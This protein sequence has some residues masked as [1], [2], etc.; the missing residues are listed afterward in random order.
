MSSVDQCVVCPRGTFCSVGA[1]VATP[2]APGTFNPNASAQTCTSCVSGTFQEARGRTAC[3]ACS[4][5]HYCG[6]GAAAALP[7]PGG[8]FSNRTSLR[9]MEQCVPAPSG[10]F[11]GIGQ[12]AA[13]ACPIGTFASGNCSI[14]CGACPPGT[15]ADAIA[16]TA[17]RWCSPGS[18]CSAD[19]QIPCAESTYNSE[20]GAS[21][22]TNCTR[23]PERTST[24]E[25]TGATSA[26]NCSCSVDFYLP[27][28]RVDERKVN[29][30]V[31]GSVLHVPHRIRLFQ[32]RR[33]SHHA[34]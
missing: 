15:F 3:V 27:C 14:S 33:S 17:C 13:E 19:R 7:C 4:R 22:I 28:A 20:P 16:S 26:A 1:A 32:K 2:C 21:L 31:S 24:N 23:C 18:W 29:A 25:V 12:S 8:Y 11:A 6:D 5:G 30:R 9:H 34:R 10:F